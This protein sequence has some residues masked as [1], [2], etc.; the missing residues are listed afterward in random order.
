MEDEGG[1]PSP[2]AMPLPC[3]GCPTTWGH[4]GVSTE[5]Q[6]WGCPCAPP[7]LPGSSLPAAL[8]PV[9]TDQPLARGAPA[10]PPHQEISSQPQERQ[11][12]P[13]CHQGDQGLRRRV[14][15]A[16]RTLLFKGFYSKLEKKNKTQN[17]TPKRAGSGTNRKR[18][19]LLHRLQTMLLAT[20]LG[21]RTS[22]ELGFAAPALGA[23]TGS[24]QPGGSRGTGNFVLWST[25][26]RAPG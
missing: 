24:F 11:Q 17:K 2:C 23:L 8:P 6:G 9:S 22:A 15:V 1:S 7:V 21:N 16:P 19:H 10:A 4:T 3:L 12:Q 26:F 5:P 14:P 20:S 18:L 13:R 25:R